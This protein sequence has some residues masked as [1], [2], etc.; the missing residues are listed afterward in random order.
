[1]FKLTHIGNIKKKKKKDIIS[2][3]VITVHTL[4]KHD[5]ILQKNSI[6]VI[7]L[8]QNGQ[9]LVACDI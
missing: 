4:I 2:E 3:L 6:Y 5:E 1:M 9:N 7:S 8:V